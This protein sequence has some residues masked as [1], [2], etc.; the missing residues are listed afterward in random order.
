MVLLPEEIWEMIFHRVDGTVDLL[1]LSLVCKDWY[2]IIRCDPRFTK[3]LALRW[4]L[5]RPYQQQ[6]LT[7]FQHLKIL[8]LHG[9]DFPLFNTQNKAIQQLLDQLERVIVHDFSRSKAVKHLVFADNKI[10]RWL[11]KIYQGMKR[12][13]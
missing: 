8:E 7:A 13:I 3:H 11:V 5:R 1:Q 10:R 4:N 9:D 2:R 6:F 12:L